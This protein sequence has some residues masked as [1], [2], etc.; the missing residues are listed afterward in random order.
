[1]EQPASVTAM[2]PDPNAVNAVFY[3]LSTLAQTCAALAALVGA[4]ALY[5]LQAMREAH[6]GNERAIRAILTAIVG[7]SASSA[8]S[9]FNWPLD[10]VLRTAR[11]QIADAKRFQPRLFEGLQAAMTEWNVFD[12][13]YA[14]AL[15]W[16][17]G[18]EAWNLAAI[19]AALIGFAGVTWL[20]AHWSVFVCS[21]I[22]GSVVTVAVTGGAL[23]VIARSDATTPPK[24]SSLEG[25]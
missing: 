8:N 4:L 20:A 11:A 9:P 5:K 23:F 25:G 24:S 22:V 7:A 21:L 3:A 19:F 16:F 12:L 17:V 14:C 15:K 10:E 2:A 6:T 18:F 1:M 13:R